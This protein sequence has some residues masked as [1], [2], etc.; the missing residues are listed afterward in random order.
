MAGREYV[1]FPFFFLFQRR[2]QTAR[3][4]W[5]ARHLFFFLSFFF[6]FIITFERRKKRGV[7]KEMSLIYSGTSP[8][9]YFFFS[10]VASGGDKFHDFFSSFSLNEITILFFV[11]IEYI[12]YLLLLQTHVCVCE[13]G[14]RW[15]G[16]F[17]DRNVLRY[18]AY[19]RT[20]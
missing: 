3:W 17:H 10:C 12:K 8:R 18:V 13:K 19:V 11:S 1:L 5:W 16:N 9:S 14:H 15:L 6:Y 2:D 20:T 4:W 7:Y